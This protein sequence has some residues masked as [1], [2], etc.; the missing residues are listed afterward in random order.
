MYIFTHNNYEGGKDESRELLAFAMDAYQEIADVR[1]RRKGEELVSMI[2]IG[3]KGKPFI[4]GWQHF[5]VS[6]SENTWV[7]VFDD[8][9]CGIDVQYEKEAKFEALARKCFASEDI[10]AALESPSEFYRFWARKEAAAK[11]IGEGVMTELPSVSDNTI[12]MNG[13]EWHMFD[14]ELLGTEDGCHAALCANMIPLEIH[15]YGI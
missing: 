12:M 5:S 6:H 10:E 8:Y 9:E 13:D 1:P 15:Y 14:I 7:V 2:E 4:P 3:E 11:A